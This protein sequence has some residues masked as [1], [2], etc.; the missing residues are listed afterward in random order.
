VLRQTERSHVVA[1][2]IAPVREED[3]VLVRPMSD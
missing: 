2:P 1:P 3:R